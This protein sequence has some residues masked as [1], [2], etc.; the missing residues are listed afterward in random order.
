VVRADGGR[1]EDRGVARRQ[2][3]L[4]Q[5]AQ[6]PVVVV[7]VVAAELGDDLGEFGVRVVDGD[8]QAVT[9]HR[10]EG[11][12]ARRRRELARGVERVVDV[13]EERAQLGHDVPGG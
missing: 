6:E 2:R 9:D 11:G 13:E 1:H 8:P 7:R 5:A 12:A 4:R 10:V 3:A